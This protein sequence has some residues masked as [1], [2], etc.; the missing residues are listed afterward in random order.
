MGRRGT[1]LYIGSKNI[2]MAQ[3]EERSGEIVLRRLVVE[4]TPEGSIEGGIIEDVN[5]L[6]EAVRRIADR[7]KLGRRVGLAL[8]IY[9]LAMR[10]VTLPR[11]SETEL[12][13]LIHI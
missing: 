3:V 10:V 8:P 6:A 5:R 12:L 11:M 9:S 7:E 13:S 1:G 4:S 2:S